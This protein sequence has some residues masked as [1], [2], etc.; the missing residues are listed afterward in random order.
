MDDLLKLY[1]EFKAFIKPKSI[2]DKERQYFIDRVVG[3]LRKHLKLEWFIRNKVYNEVYTITL[4]GNLSENQD[5]YLKVIRDEGESSDVARVIVYI[6][7]DPWPGKWFNDIL[8]YREVDLFKFKN[9]D[10][11]C[12]ELIDMLVEE[13]DDHKKDQYGPRLVSALND[14]R[15]I[16]LS[17]SSTMLDN[18]TRGELISYTAENSKP[19]YKEEEFLKTCYQNHAFEFDATHSSSFS[20]EID[21]K[22]KHKQE[23]TTKRL[24]VVVKGN[25]YHIDTN[26]HVRMRFGRGEIIAKEFTGLSIRKVL[27][28]LVDDINRIYNPVNPG[29]L[30]NESIKETT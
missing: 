2:K 19:I 30:P 14:M 23:I 10:V 16:N 27:E 21:L 26:V 1:K 24:I 12:R 29:V 8:L 17:D 11:Y 20:F 18:L 22:V 28:R 13:I 15:K 3:V 6:H 25:L 4:A 9:D 7:S 5:V